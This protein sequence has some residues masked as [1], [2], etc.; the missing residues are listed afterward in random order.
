[1]NSHVFRP[2]KELKKYYRLIAGIVYGILFIPAIIILPFSILGAVI[3]AVPIVI[4]LWFTLYWISRFYDTL[5]YRVTDEHVTVKKG[6]WWEK[7]TTVPMEMITNVDKTQNPFERWYGIGKVHVQT[8]GAGGTQATR[9]EAV[10]LGVKSMDEIKEEV[11]L[12]A[13]GVKSPTELKSEESLLNEIREEL[14]E[15]KEILKK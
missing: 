7:E 10:F 3:Y 14:V 4:L 9:A 12:R 15:I 8:A 6:V 5:E 13:K 2:E 1:M 11:A